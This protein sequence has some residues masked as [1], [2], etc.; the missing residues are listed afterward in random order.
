[1]GKIQE[2]FLDFLLK[3]QHQS[4][5]KT[6]LFHIFQDT[7][8]FTFISDPITP[9]YNILFDVIMIASILA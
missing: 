2:I 8:S 1:M 5:S 3:F 9:I 4:M 6:L 7:F